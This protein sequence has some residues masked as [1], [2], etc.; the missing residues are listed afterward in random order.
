MI[1]FSNLENKIF[2]LNSLPPI[3]CAINSSPH[4]FNDECNPPAPALNSMLPSSTP[5][6]HRHAPQYTHFSRSNAGTPFSP[7]VIACP[8]HISTHTFGSHSR[9]NSG[10]RKTIWLA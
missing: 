2:V 5:Q 8:E 6:F 10:R 1:P 7:R 4:Q 9:H 3:L